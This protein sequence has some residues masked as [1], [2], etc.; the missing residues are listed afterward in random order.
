M[1]AALRFDLMFVFCAFA[2]VGAILVGAL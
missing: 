2:F 1:V